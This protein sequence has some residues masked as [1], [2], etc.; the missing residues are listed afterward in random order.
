MG[1]FSKLGKEFIDIIE[2]LSDDNNAMVHRFERYDN[3]I[4]N[5]AKLVVREGQTAVFIN[6]GV[7]ADVFGPGTYTLATANLPIL[8][9]LKGW[10]HGFESPF[11]AEVYFVKTSRFRDLKWGTKNPITLRDSEFGM[12]R[13]RAFG[14]YEIKVKDP[15]KI[16]REVVGTDSAFGADE[17]V[18][19]LRNFIVAR[20]TD[21]LGESKIPVLDLAANYDELGDFVKQ[22]LVIEFEDKYGIDLTTFLVENIS[23]P[24]AVEEA[25]DKRTSMGVLGNL[26]DYTKFQMA[27]AI[28]DAAK[29]DGGL[30]GAGMGLGLGVGMAGQMANTFGQAMA[31]QQ[32]P[33]QQA[34]PPP[35]AP[36]PLPTA[37]TFFI[38]VGGAQQGPYDV[39][40]LTAYAAQGQLTRE[41]LVWKQGM[42]AWTAAGQVPELL[43]VFNT[44]PPMAPPP[45]I[46]GA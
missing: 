29:Q 21:I 13:L 2:W 6:E 40:T 43:A 23:L 3:E 20:F 9:K 8:G 31:P 41:T 42:A 38:A 12:V 17:I 19:Q 37:V 45:P 46:P 36:P 26:N 28:P 18:N 1:F 10:A 16:L 39:P 11:K 32:Q 15:G 22:K 27:N 5:G 30:A 14:T 7:M 33:P 24:P 35:M 34:A 4:K 44:P 25:L